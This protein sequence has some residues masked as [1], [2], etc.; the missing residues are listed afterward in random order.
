MMEGAQN[1]LQALVWTVTE[2]LNAFWCCRDFLV[3]PPRRGVSFLHKFSQN[4]RLWGFLFSVRFCT[5]QVVKRISK[6]LNPLWHAL[7]HITRVIF[8]YFDRSS[9]K[10]KKRVREK[11]RKV[12]FYISVIYSAKILGELYIFFFPFFPFSRCL[13]E[14]AE[15]RVRSVGCL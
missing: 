3:L 6:T 13:C 15:L 4:A 7:E 10:K 14:C 8:T 9:A 1:S 2:V 12:S 5:W 11:N